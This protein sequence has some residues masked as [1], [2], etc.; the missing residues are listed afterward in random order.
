MNQQILMQLLEQ[1]QRMSRNAENQA[2]TRNL[3]QALLSNNNNNHSMMYAQAHPHPHSHAPTFNQT[4][5]PNQQQPVHQ[6]QHSFN[7]SSPTTN[8]ILSS[9]AVSQ[10][11]QCIESQQLS[12]L[13]VSL[14][15]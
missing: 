1:N 8:D 5:Y 14:E 2:Q 9:Q 10:V 15:T 12:H 6:F 11:H 3:F 4:S 7:P 13:L